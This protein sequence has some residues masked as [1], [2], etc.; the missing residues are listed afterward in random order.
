MTYW[1]SILC[2]KI[3]FI[4]I[5]HFLALVIK[6]IFRSMEENKNKKIKRNVLTLVTKNE[7]S[8]FIKSS[9]YYI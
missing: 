4:K 2:F 5:L 6:F 1:N 8:A 9:T 7:I 3:K